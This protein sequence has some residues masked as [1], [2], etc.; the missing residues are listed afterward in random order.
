MATVDPEKY[1]ALELE[2]QK[3]KSEN[4]LI[5]MSW[6]IEKAFFKAGGKRNNVLDDF[7]FFEMVQGHAS[8]FVKVD[9]QG[10]LI[11]IDPR[12]GTR[13]KTDA[14]K[15]YSLRDLMNKFKNSGLSP[16]TNCF[17]T[18]GNSATPSFAQNPGDYSDRESLREIK[19]PAARLSYAG[20]LGIN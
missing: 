20:K 11:I 6:E 2:N 3:L 5:K 14:G 16:L 8:K 1:A 18:N 4:Q 7:T 13:L 17:D 9:E 12:D 19:D 15:N 10:K